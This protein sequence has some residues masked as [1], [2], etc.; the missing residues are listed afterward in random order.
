MNRFISLFALLTSIMMFLPGF[1]LASPGH[2][3]SHDEAPQLAAG[4]VLP[5]FEA[6]SD[7]FE[8]V[9]VLHS[10]ELSVFVDRFNSNAPVLGAKVELES[11]STKATGQFHED[12]GDYSFALASFNKPGSHPITLTIKDGEDIDMLAGNLVVPEQVASHAPSSS[13]VR[14]AGIWAF[15][16]AVLAALTWLGRRLYKRRN[17]GALK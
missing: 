3:H 9:G 1:A 14:Q 12:H 8:V 17:L 15:G 11:A 2:D 6:H 7:L 13:F 10:D 4:P 5:R 16:L